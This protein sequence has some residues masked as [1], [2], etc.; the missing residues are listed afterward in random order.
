MIE[1]PCLLVIVPDPGVA[2]RVVTFWDA[3]LHRGYFWVVVPLAARRPRG[4]GLKNGGLWKSPRTR[5]DMKYAQGCYQAGFG[6]VL[7]CM[8][9]GAVALERSEQN[10]RRKG[11][12]K[13]GTPSSLVDKTA[14]FVESRYRDPRLLASNKHV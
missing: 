12:Q 4:L 11:P 5:A 14:A 8:A 13:S 9:H 10:R 1:A 3:A 6:L 7:Y 2:A